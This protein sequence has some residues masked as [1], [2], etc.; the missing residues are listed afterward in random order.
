[1]RLSIQARLLLLSLGAVLGVAVITMWLAYREAEHEVE[2]LIDAQLTQYARIMLALAH[3]GDDDEV[4][5][6]HISGHRYASH[7]IFQIWQAGEHGDTLLLRS[8]EAP[9]TWPEGVARQGYSDMRLDGTAW[10]C[11][12]AED[13]DKARYVLA[14]IDTRIQADLTE[15]I[16]WGNVKPYLIGLPLLGLLLAWAVRGGLAPLRRLEAELGGRSPERLDPLPEAAQ[17]KELRPLAGAMNRLFDRLGKA[18]DNERRFTSDAAHELRTPL[19]AMKAQLQVAQRAED[20]EEVRDAVRKALRGTDR[21]THLVSQLLALARLESGPAKAPREQVALSDIVA[22]CLADAVEQAAKAG[23]ALESEIEA[24]IR[25]AGNTDLLAVLTR[26]LLDNALRYTPA[27]GRARL[28]LRGESGHVVLSVRDN[29][30]GVAETD[31]DKLGQRFQRFGAQHV[32][33]VGLGLSIVGRIADLHG[34]YLTF[35]AGLDGRGLGVEVSLPAS[36]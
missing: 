33:G 16:A 3:V 19:A 30:P 17:T 1:M 35:G 34:A 32:D 24:C 26:N 12:T 28:G 29:G 20:V 2:E 5:A 36:P 4:E 23:V 10:R 31:R 9:H 27:G 25:V 15:D 18:W 8:P 21:M 11:F 14:A 13:S 6:P 7:V 22:G